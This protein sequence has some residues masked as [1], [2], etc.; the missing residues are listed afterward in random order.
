MQDLEGFK[1]S[2]F[3][4]LKNYW[5]ADVFELE[6]FKNYLS[7]LEDCDCDTDLLQFVD[8]FHI[9]NFMEIEKEELKEYEEQGL[10]VYSN[11]QA[12]KYAVV[13]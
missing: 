11:E 12:E 3:D 5:D 10:F 1:K 13:Y 7:G 8:N 9:N 4:R 6:V 2:A